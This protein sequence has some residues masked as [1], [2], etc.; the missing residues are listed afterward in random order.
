M[1]KLA[2][3]ISYFLT[4]EYEKIDDAEMDGEE[5]VIDMDHILHC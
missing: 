1:R 2:K 4:G 3:A 5:G